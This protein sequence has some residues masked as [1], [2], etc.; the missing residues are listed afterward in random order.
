MVC[1]GNYISMQL[2]E[3]E[4]DRVSVKEVGR[5]RPPAWDTYHLHD[6]GA[7]LGQKLQAPQGQVE[8]LTVLLIRL[9]AVQ[10]GACHHLENTG[11]HPH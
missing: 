7:P 8:E 3:A 9:L 5:G 2:R 4:A 10:P 1:C 6:M 11:R